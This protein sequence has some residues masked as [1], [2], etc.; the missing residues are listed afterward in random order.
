MINDVG[1]NG[2]KST[3][4]EVRKVH[5]M[6]DQNFSSKTFNL[7]YSAFYNFFVFLLLP[8]IIITIPDRLKLQKN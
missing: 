2:G 3:R 6:T 7:F 5:G 8:L 4:N 1:Y